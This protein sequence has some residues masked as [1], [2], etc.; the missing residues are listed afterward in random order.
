MTLLMQCNNDVND[1]DELN[2]YIYISMYVCM[3]VCIIV[4][5]YT[6]MTHPF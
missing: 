3:Y 2:N 6:V 4:C 5:M 1:D